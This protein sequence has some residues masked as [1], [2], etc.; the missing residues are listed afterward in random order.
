MKKKVIAIMGAA[1]LLLSACGGQSG[2][3]DASASD[4]GGQGTVEKSQQGG[5]DT[6]HPFLFREDIC[7]RGFVLRKI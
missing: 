1:L 2:K 4:S 7:I 5:Q 3:S 6:K